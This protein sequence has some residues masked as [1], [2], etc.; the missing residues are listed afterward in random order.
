MTDA[1]KEMAS[2]SDD[3]QRNTDVINKPGPASN[4]GNNAS[5]TLQTAQ[6][7]GVLGCCARGHAV[8]VIK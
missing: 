1:A 4:E 2:S 3:V 5:L 8:L 7:V 6:L